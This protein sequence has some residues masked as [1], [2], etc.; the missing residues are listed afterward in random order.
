VTLPPEPTAAELSGADGVE[1]SRALQA[2]ITETAS[3]ASPITKLTTCRLIR[4]SGMEG[5]R[6]LARSHE[7]RQGKNG[8]I[9]R[10]YNRRAGV[11]SY[12]GRFSS[13]DFS[14]VSTSARSI[15][16]AASAIMNSSVSSGPIGRRSGTVSP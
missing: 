1:T 3:T 12:L 2:H 13:S 16:R 9:G 10:T 15:V 6:I 7:E 14:R 11:P 5:G 8:A 4:F